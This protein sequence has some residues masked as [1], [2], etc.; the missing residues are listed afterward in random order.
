MQMIQA[1]IYGVPAS[2]IDS[3]YGNITWNKWLELEKVRT[4]R[5]P[6]RTAVIHT[7]SKR[8][9]LWVNNIVNYDIPPK[10]VEFEDLI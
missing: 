4:E 9:A 7:R 10:L 3:Q 8:K 1:T 6:G 2:M 5:N